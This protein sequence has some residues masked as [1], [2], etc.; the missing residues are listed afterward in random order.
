MCSGVTGRAALVK[1]GRHRGRCQRAEPGASAAHGQHLGKI[2][3]IWKEKYPNKNQTDPLSQKNIHTLSYVGLFVCLKYNHV[4]KERNWKVNGKIWK[5][6]GNKYKQPKW[7]EHLNQLFSE[8]RK[9]RQPLCWPHYPQSST[10][11]EISHFT[12]KKP[13]PQPV[14]HGQCQVHP[15]RQRLLK[16]RCL[17]KTFSAKT[18]TLKI[19]NHGSFPLTNNRC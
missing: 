18:S 4:Q 6:R 12:Q 16:Q 5:R 15:K 17:G 1:H 2:K 11:P 7:R 10:E 19:K 3:I 8:K 14:G 9:H 13:S